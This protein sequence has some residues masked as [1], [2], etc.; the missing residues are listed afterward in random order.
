MSYVDVG[1]KGILRRGVSRYTGFLMGV[2]LV[3]LRDIIKRVSM[4]ERL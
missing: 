3:Y 4:V 1:R 2:N